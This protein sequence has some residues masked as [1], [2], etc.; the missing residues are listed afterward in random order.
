MIGG[1]RQRVNPTL[2]IPG[3]DV[4]QL[5]GGDGHGMGLVREVIRDYLTG[6]W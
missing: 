6:V 3:F 5:P 4:A 2:A 1:R